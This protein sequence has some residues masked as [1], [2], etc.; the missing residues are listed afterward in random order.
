[1]LNVLN[2][3][4]DKNSGVHT[5]RQTREYIM[6]QENP[7]AAANALIVE[8]GGKPLPK[9]YDARITAMNMVVDYAT[10]GAEFDSQLSYE[11]GIERA[12]ILRN[13]Y[14]SFAQE[15]DNMDVVIDTPKVAVTAPVRVVKAKAPKAEKAVKVK[16]EKKT[17][18]ESGE[19][20]RP[21]L[22]SGRERG[23]MRDVVRKIYLDNQKAPNT[24]IIRL[25]C[26]A[27]NI[28]KTN[29]YTHVYLVKNE[30]KK[31]GMI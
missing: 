25:I 28:P 9:L 15:D 19:R 29:A 8:L 5:T 10:K 20:A 16:A 7:R 26:E 4:V 3:I 2:K 12:R 30:L 18:K 11:H 31:K 24:E 1:M 13:Q 6:Q 21:V 14:P 17:K 22:K 23:A 27:L